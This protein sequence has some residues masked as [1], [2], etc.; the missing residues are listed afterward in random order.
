MENTQ[1][2]ISDTQLKISIKHS[3]FIVT[4]W[5]HLKGAQLSYDS[6]MKN[7]NLKIW[8]NVLESDS[9]SKHYTED[10]DIQ[11]RKIKA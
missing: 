11:P 8:V 1:E 10:S 5:Y 3:E 2:Q 6:K 4:V 9:S 7:T